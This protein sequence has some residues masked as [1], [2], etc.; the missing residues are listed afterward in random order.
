MIE[1]CLEVGVPSG[2]LLGRLKAGQDVTLPNGK[3][4]KA[5]DVRSPDMPSPIFIGKLIYYLS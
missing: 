2:P 1:K 5:S 3:L 4:V